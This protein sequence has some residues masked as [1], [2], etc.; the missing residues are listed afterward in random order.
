MLNEFLSGYPLLA[1]VLAFVLAC[2]PLFKFAHSIIMSKSV[3]RAQA[4]DL[5]FK[6]YGDTSN[7]SHRLVIEQMFQSNFNLKLD[8]ETITLLLALPNPTETLDL[9]SKSKRYLV[10][11]NQILEFETKFK[12]SKRRKLERVLRPSRNIILYGIFGTIAGTAGL[13]VLKNFNMDE[14][15]TIND[16][17]FNG[18]I[19]SFLLII[20]ILS[21]K[22]ALMSL[23]DKINIRDAEK[24]EAKFQPKTVKKIFGT[25]EIVNNLRRSNL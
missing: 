11:N 21:A 14:F 1:G 8:Y 23:T 15:F 22:F 10:S 6:S 2:I 13:Y 19:W 17:I 9:Y 16:S 25:T 24:L 5:V 20:S 3:L 12:C 18:A 7:L 4:L